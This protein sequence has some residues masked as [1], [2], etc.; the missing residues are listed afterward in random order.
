MLNKSPFLSCTYVRNVGEPSNPT[1]SHC[2]RHQILNDYAN[3]Q[4]STAS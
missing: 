2:P 3:P 4:V 1:E